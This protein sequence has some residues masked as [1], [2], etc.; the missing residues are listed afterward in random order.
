MFPYPSGALHMGHIRN[1]SMGD[2]LARFLRKR[3]RNVLYTMGFDSFGM[4]AENAA[5][6]YKTKPHDWT[7]NNID[8]MTK[9]LKRM[10]YSYDWNREAITCLPEAAAE[11]IAECEKYG[12]KAIT[13][14]ANVENSA[15]VYSDRKSVV[16]ERV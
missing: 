6:K 14:Q 15:D 4:P 3:G 8:Y 5:I 7:L 11:T 16:R 1:Y 12:V 9:Q 2:M 13:V 10:G